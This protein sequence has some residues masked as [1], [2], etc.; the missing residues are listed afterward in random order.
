MSE[1]LLPCAFCDSSKISI[2]DFYL[3]GQKIFKLLCQNCGI[4]TSILL[5]LNHLKEIWNT[6]PSP[7]KSS[8]DKFQCDIC[9]EMTFPEEHFHSCKSCIKKSLNNRPSQW[10]IA[11][12]RM[13]EKDGRYLVIEDHPYPW[14]GVSQMLNGKFTIP[15]KYWQPLPSIPKEPKE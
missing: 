2:I 7:H 9:G 10:I 12:E 6:R 11:T 14:T 15:I 5:N 1:T 13:P 4:S 8:D 3:E